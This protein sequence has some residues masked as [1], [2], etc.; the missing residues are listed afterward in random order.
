MFQDSGSIAGDSAL[1]DLEE[2]QPQT[3]SPASYTD[4]RSDTVKYEKVESV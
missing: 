1:V 2:R 3:A 4:Q